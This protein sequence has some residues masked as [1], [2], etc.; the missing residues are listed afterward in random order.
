M[1]NRVSSDGNSAF[2]H[3]GFCYVHLTVNC[4][5]LKVQ[6]SPILFSRNPSPVIFCGERLGHRVTQITT[7]TLD[8]HIASSL[9]GWLIPP[10]CF[11]T[12]EN[13]QKQHSSLLSM[14]SISQT[15]LLLGYIFSCFI[16]FFNREQI[17]RFPTSRKQ[18]LK[19]AIC[20]CFSWS[21]D[22]ISL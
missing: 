18:R 20:L 16:G 5:P 21:P 13:A 17:F 12:W 7:W 6:H 9:R 11:S 19:R 1:R 2:T 4:V 10:R 3:W 8:L 15:L 22:D 14:V